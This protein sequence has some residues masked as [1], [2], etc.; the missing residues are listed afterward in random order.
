MILKSMTGNKRKRTIPSAPDERHARPLFMEA[1]MLFLFIR[2][3]LRLGK[4]K[5]KPCREKSAW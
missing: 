4:R 5:K 1:G 2:K 3:L